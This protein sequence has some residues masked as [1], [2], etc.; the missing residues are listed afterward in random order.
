MAGRVVHF[1]AVAKDGDKIRDFYGKVFGWSF[2]VMPEMDYGLVDNGGKGING[3]IGGLG[4]GDGSAPK[5]MAPFYVAVADP[6]AA[7][8]KAES[9]GGKTTMPVMEIPNVVTLAQFT[10]PDGNLI[11]LVKDDGTQQ[12]PPSAAK[13]AENPVT[14]FEIAGKDAK[15]T[16]DFYSQ[17]FG[18]K[19]NMMDEYGMI[20]GDEHSIGGGV[21]SAP[22]GAHAIWYAEVSDPEAKLKEIEASGGK[23]VVPATDIGM[24]V[25]AIFQDPA[26]SKV[27]LFKS[28][29]QQ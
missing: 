9:L 29:Q 28:N 27:G 8:D 22:D 6:Q 13:P 19:Y 12:M 3:G 11:G 16:Q 24:V 17:L 7:L 23:T 4:E 2:N 26:G 5:P 1:E 15:K 25:F 20:D 10:D 14:W 18:W 21:G